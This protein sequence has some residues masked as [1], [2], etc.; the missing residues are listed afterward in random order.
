[1]VWKINVSWLPALVGEVARK[2]ALFRVRYK[3]LLTVDTSL[4][5][6]FWSGG[7]IASSQ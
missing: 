7:A 2:M 6:C 5:M 1:M 4:S 3:K